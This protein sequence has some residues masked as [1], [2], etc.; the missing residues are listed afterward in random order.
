MEKN[1]DEVVCDQMATIIKWINIKVYH[2]PEKN[3]LL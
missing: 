2:K 3:L 1:Y